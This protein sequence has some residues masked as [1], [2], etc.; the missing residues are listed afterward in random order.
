MRKYYYL[1]FAFFQV[2]I[3]FSQGWQPM[4]ARSNSLGNASVCLDDVWAFHH[5][6]GATAGITKIGAG[7]SYENRFLLKELQSQGLVVAVP[8]KKGVLTFGGQSFGYNQFRTYKTGVGYAL[9]LADFISAGVQM[10]YNAVR[11][12]GYGSH[13]TVTAEAGVLAKISDYWSIGFSVF[14]ISRNKLSNYMED[15]YSSVM[16]FGTSYKL[17]KSVLLL[18]EAEKQVEYALRIKTGVEYL[19]ME[20]LYI[21]GGFATAPIEFSFGFGYAFKGVYKLDFGTSYHQ[22]LGWSPHTSFTVQLK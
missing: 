10:N 4:G 5:N 19:P 21:R 18:A 15:R 16:R 11:I 14:N 7:I 2:I 13:Q 8:M 3:G 1:F 6:P 22:I 17:S 9:K 12:S 20:N